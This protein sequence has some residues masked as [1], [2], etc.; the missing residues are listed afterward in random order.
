MKK[1]E[2]DSYTIHTSVGNETAELVKMECKNCGASLELTDP[3]H[4]VCPF[5]GQKYLIDEAK[6]TVIEIHVDG[7]SREIRSALEDTKRLLLAVG[8]IALLVTAII[9]GFNIAARKSVF[10]SS[11]TNIPADGNGQLLVIF[12]EDVF[13]KPYKEITA[14]EFASIKYIRCGY[15]REG[16]ESFNAIWY[17]FTDY[18]DCASEEE[19]QETVK[20]WY[21]RTKEV[22][23][24]SDY[25]KFTGL[26]RI[27]TMDTVW[28]SLL[29]FSPDSRISYVDTDDRLD[30]VTSVLDPEAVKVLHI[31]IMGNNLD[32][33]GQFTN[34]EELE[35]DTNL[36]HQTV[37][38]SGISACGKLKTL[39]LNCAGDYT[40]LEQIGKLSQLNSLYLSSVPLK[41]CKFLG[42]L[43]GL[44][45][46]SISAG[47]GGDLSVLASLPD[48]K[49]LCLLDGEYIPPDQLAVLKRAEKLEGLRI[50][51]N[52][53]ES[54]A[55]LIK[56]TGL[57]DLDLHL[58]IPEYDEETGTRGIDLSPLSDLLGLKRLHLDSFWE[59]DLFGGEELFNLPG[60]TSLSLGNG[61]ANDVNLVMDEELL[62]ENKSLTDISLRNCYPKNQ[63]G[64]PVDFRFLSRYPNVRRLYLD[65]CE[66]EDISF[67]GE[68]QDLR[69]CSL[70]ENRIRD[71]SPLSRLK[72]LELV[73]IDKEGKAR[74][75]LSQDVEIYTDPYYMEKALDLK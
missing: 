4:A 71:F 57:K 28:L 38:V 17:S 30:T 44:S 8:V 20:K 49:R 10:S 61:V 22:S 51:V 37:D 47:E 5:C 23:W 70:Q 3:T 59:C 69:V 41:E 2:E 18:Q 32:Q 48:L 74:L 14:E 1:K 63:S 6:G 55:E 50:S 11:D 19:F 67:I 7:S 72:K 13:G 54:L 64:E 62:Q 35:V 26:T 45:E 12:C 16:G 73:C 60:L 9:F 36:D 29:T 58:A 53:R 27:G 68:F 33:V 31:G 42:E 43:K 66:L 75:E 56:M 34:L 15:Q 52:E 65:G 24:P 46:L 21:Y 39:R 25:T 40:G